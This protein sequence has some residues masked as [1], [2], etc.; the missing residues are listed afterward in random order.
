MRVVATVAAP[1][2][3]MAQSMASTLGAL[4]AT[5]AAA[6]LGVTVEA[7]QP[8]VVVTCSNPILVVLKWVGVVAAKME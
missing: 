3:S 1:D 8:P 7:I 2:A 4:D 6:A 5:S